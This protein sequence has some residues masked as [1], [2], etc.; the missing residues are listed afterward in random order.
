MKTR[1]GFVSN[2]SSSSYVCD[3]TGEAFEVQDACFRD[4][5]LAQCEAGH[6][7]QTRFLVPYTPSYPTKEVMLN[8]LCEVTD[9]KRECLRFLEMNEFELQ[10]AYAKKFLNSRKDD[11][12]RP[13]ECPLCTMNKVRDTHLVTYLLKK[14]GITREQL[15]A[16]IR[17]EFTNNFPAFERWIAATK[18]N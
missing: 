4:A 17:E 11:Y 2:S 8:S 13:Q 14:Q 1:N 3:I 7:F 16:Q 6:Y 18:T 5:G 9:S 12:V 15:I 10:Q